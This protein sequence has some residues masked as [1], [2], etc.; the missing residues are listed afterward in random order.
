M[1]EQIKVVFRNVLQSIALENHIR[2]KIEALEKIHNRIIGCQATIEKPQKTKE[3]SGLYRVRL[4]ITFPPRHEIVIK[5][6]SK[7]SGHYKNLELLVNNAFKVAIRRLEN[8]K[9]KKCIRAKVRSRR[10]RYDN[11][12]FQSFPEK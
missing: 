9:E 8:L 10:N 7:I 1:Q 3:A 4:D 11:L 6:E 12:T 5:K 2:E